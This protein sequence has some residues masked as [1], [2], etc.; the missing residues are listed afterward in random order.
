MKL[1]SGVNQWST[2]V[3]FDDPN[4]AT[5]MNNGN[6]SFL[7]TINI[8]DYF[9]VPFADVNW[10]NV[11]LNDGALN[12]DAP[13]AEGNVM[14]DTTDSP[15]FGGGTDACTDMILHIDQTP[16][17]ND[18]NQVSS[19]VLFS[20]AGDSETCVDA[21][22]GLVRIDLDYGIACPEG[23]SAMLLAGAS[24]IGFY[25]GANN[26]S[27]VTA[28]DDANAMQL[29]NDGNDNFSVI[30][31]ANTYY[32]TPFD[33]IVNIQ[34]IGNNGPND[35]TIDGTMTWTNVLKDP[36]DGGVFGN[37]DPCSN[38]SLIIAEAPTCDLETGTNNVVLQHS[39]K[40]A[41]NPF[42]NRTFL[43][44][45]NPNNEAFDLMISGMTGRLVRTMKNISAERV[46]IER[47]NMAA[48]IYL[49]TLT[50]EKGNFA[51]TKLVV[52]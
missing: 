2:T 9:G 34:I 6:D 15:G 32:G 36:A 35:G 20:D 28:W 48:G 30:I 44:F 29:M 24:T 31:D 13:W 49:A 4:A 10:L 50:D 39:F 8:M 51:T 33:S 47:E 40:V 16:T 5:L 37:P 45:D 46:L 43:E 27:A 38:I 22:D 23:D 17:C 42:H 52:K 25:S 12:P 3:A 21:T 18:L 1:H 19:L 26:F 14:R 11:I 7:I 41:P